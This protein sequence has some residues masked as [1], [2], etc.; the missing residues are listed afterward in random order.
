MIYLDYN[1][2]SPL[3]SDA[4]E[5]MAPWWGVPANPSSVHRAG[6]RASM[7]VERAREQVAALV[8]ADPAGVV[9]TSGATE[10]N[11]LGIRGA[12]RPGKAVWSSAIEHPCV[13]DAVRRCGAEPRALPVDAEGRIVLPDRVDEGDLLVVMAANHE[14]GVVQPFAEAAVLAARCGAWLH[15]DAVQAAGRLPLWSVMVGEGPRSLVLSSHKIAGP[16]GVGALVLRDGGPFPALWG[17][18][19]QERGRRAGTMNVPGIVGFGAACAAIHPD[20][21]PLRD[22]LEAGLVA[23]GARVIG[24]GRRLP[25]TS[26]VVFAGIPGETVVQALDLAG[27]CVSAGAACASGSVDP[28]PVL[29][30]MGDPEP[31]G[32]VRFSLGAENTVGEIDAVLA[33]LDAV[34]PALRP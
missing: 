30:A 10:A 31:A 23:R 6:Q 33:A 24:G 20:L 28:S 32:I 17:G 25:N 14:T 29:V 1:A 16:P 21:A 8:G 22:R 34:L 7:A 5:A 26:A 3:G 18:G 15:V 27:V 9:F 2:T 12:A 19:P 11:H 4:R 13:R